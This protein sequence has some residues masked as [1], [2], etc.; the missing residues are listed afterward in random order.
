MGE[1]ELERNDNSSG[2]L[3][4]QSLAVLDMEMVFP[5]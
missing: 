4:R 3:E 2:V 1:P 5:A